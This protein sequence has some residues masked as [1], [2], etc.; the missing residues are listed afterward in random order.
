MIDPG[1]VPVADTA[2]Y[3]LLKW[4]VDISCSA[5][6]ARQ[7]LKSV[8]EGFTPAVA[9]ANISRSSP[10]TRFLRRSLI[11]LLAFASGQAIAAQTVIQRR[12]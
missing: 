3:R 5:R 12:V 2:Q 7:C 10:N 4:E 6:W 8:S 1:A 9:F 11:E